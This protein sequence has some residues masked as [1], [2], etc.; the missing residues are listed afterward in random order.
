MP[1][2]TV[3]RGR[4]DLTAEWLTA[5][6]SEASDGARVESLIGIPIGHGNVATSVR[7]IPT[8]DRPTPAPPSVVAKVPSSEEASRAA[9]FA[10]R[11]YELEAAFYNELAGT[12]WV[13]RPA[14]YLARYDPDAL[15][16]VVL[17]EDLAPA[18]AGDQ[19]DGC[20]PGDAAAAMPELAALHAPRWGDPRL[21]DLAWLDRPTPEAARAMADFLP[22]LFGGFVD[23][24]RDRVEP[25]TLAVSE[26]LMASLEGYLSDRPYPWTIAH[27]D[28]R[29]DNLLFGGPRVVVVDWQTVKIGVGLS[30][31]SYFIGSALLPED[32]RQHEANLVR[33]YHSFLTDFGVDLPWGQC[34]EGY[35]RYCFDGLLMAMAA[36]MLVTR[37]PRS[38]DMFMVMVNRHGR[39][40]LDLGSEDFL[41]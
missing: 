2:L 35:R 15:G 6:L 20:S 13:N 34:W 21:L 3:P 25:Q 41:T 22:T 19:I 23:R 5:A 1:V 9:G 18:E 33:A 36:S 24:Y 17:L 26:R 28:F 8:W 39:Q 14:C 10:T 31:V 7:L 27:G 12:V 38:D 32:R 16:Y 40:A 29:L 37:T 4:D 30:D 11:T